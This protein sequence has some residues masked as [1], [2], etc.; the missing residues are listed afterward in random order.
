MS[1]LSTLLCHYT[2]GV[3][4]DFGLPWGLCG[5]YSPNFVFIS[6]PICD[7]A[8]VGL[9]APASPTVSNPHAS[10]LIF[11][12]S[13][14]PSDPP[15]LASLPRPSHRCLSLLDHTHHQ[16]AF[17]SWP[18]Y[19]SSGPCLLSIVF[20]TSL[21]KLCFSFLSFLFFL[22]FFLFNTIKYLF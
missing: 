22:S 1:L 9:A 21:L 20:P 14:L 13:P 8:A 16:H 15:C 11:T 10:Y 12:I 7:T 18:A 2:L 17:V 6:F 3:V 5:Q 19:H 4:G